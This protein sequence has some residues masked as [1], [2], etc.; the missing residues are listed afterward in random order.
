MA[1][2]TLVA[3]VPIVVVIFNVARNARDL[4]LV[5][6]RIVAVT[7]SAGESGVTSIQLEGGI[8]CVIET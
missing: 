3:K 7:V 1:S 5:C 6:K 2:V 8:P 4:H